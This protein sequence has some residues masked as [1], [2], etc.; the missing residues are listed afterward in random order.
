MILEVLAVSTESILMV[1]EPAYRS[2]KAG[3]ESCSDGDVQ[4]LLVHWIVYAAFRV[5][6]C[7]FGPVC[8]MY[9]TAKLAMVAWLRVGNGAETLYRSVIG[10]FLDAH[11]PVFD[12]WLDRY[13]AVVGKVA[14]TA[15]ALA[16]DTDVP[17]GTRENRPAAGVKDT[18]YIYDSSDGCE[19]EA[20]GTT[21]TDD[22]DGADV[23]VDRVTTALTSVPDHQTLPKKGP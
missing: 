9:A 5:V 21:T 19:L 7:F 23:D 12:A 8:P 2:H 10:P 1:L 22:E 15:A 18:T 13:D 14:N 4:R 11:G 17:G 3:L 16:K 20:Y 6:D